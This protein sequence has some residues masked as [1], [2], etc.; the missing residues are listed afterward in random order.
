MDDHGQRI[1]DAIKKAP[2]MPEEAKQ[3][4][5]SL[6]HMLTGL[7]NDIHR[8]ADALERRPVIA[9]AADVTFGQPKPN[10]WIQ[11]HRVDNRPWKGLTQDATVRVQ[12]DDGRI[13]THPLNS[14]DVDWRDVIAYQIINQ[15]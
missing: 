1:I 8:I 14:T 9:R 11:W 5:Y 10:K 7:C 13:E 15:E 12:F 2:D 4:A 6:T 3:I